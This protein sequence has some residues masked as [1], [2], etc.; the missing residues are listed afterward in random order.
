MN[1]LLR[2]IIL[3]I[4]FLASTCINI[5]MACD[6]DID[7]TDCH[8]SY[9]ESV[10]D[11][12]ENREIIDGGSVAYNPYSGFNYNGFTHW[13]I[14]EDAGETFDE[15]NIDVTSGKLWARNAGSGQRG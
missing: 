11:S 7:T 12:F 6:A 8:C 3:S 2:Y 10:F 15:T 9:D 13:S 4:V 14:I 1:N 5:A